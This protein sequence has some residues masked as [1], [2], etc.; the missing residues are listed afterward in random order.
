MEN[1]KQHSVITIIVII[2]IIIA[3]AIV[4][5]IISSS[6]SLNSQLTQVKSAISS[7]SVAEVVDEKYSE[8]TEL[9]KEDTKAKEV[10]ED[11]KEVVSEMEQKESTSLFE[12]IKEL[13]VPEKEKESIRTSFDIKESREFPG[14]YIF[15]YV[16]E[17]EKKSDSKELH[18]DIPVKP[19]DRDSLEK[20]GVVLGEIRDIWGYPP[21]ETIYHRLLKEK[22]SSRSESIKQVFNGVFSVKYAAAADQDPNF[23]G[24]YNCRANTSV[25]GYFKAYFADV[26]ANNNVGY[27]D[28][29]YGAAR[30]NEVCQ[31]LQDVA[32]LIKLDE[33]NVTPDIRFFPAGTSLPAGA[34][35]AASPYLGFSSTNLDNGA[36]HKYILS[37]Q[38][39]T[40]G[41]FDFDGLIMTN[42]N[43]GIIWDVDSPSSA[44]A[45]D[46]YTVMYHEVLHMLGFR[47]G[48]P[49]SGIIWGN[50][51]KYTTFNLFSFT[52]VSL[53]QQFVDSVTGFVQAQEGAPSPWFTT[54]DVVYQGKRN[55]VNASPDGIR[56]VYSPSVWE[57]ASSLS[58]FDMNRAPGETYIMNPTIGPNTERYIHQHE[59]EVLC[60]L[61]YTV[62]GL[63]EDPT[64]VAQDDVVM[65]ENLGDSVC[66]NPL[67]NDLSVGG[68]DLLIHTLQLVDVQ[69]GDVITYY[70][71]NDCTGAVLS[72]SDNA[73]SLLLE[74][75]SIPDMRIMQ[76]TVKDSVS[77]RYSFPAMITVVP[78]ECTTSDPD[79]HVCNGGFEM[80]PTQAISSGWG[81]Q[82]YCTNYNPA[83]TPIPWWCGY[84]GTPDIIE[85][86]SVLPADCSGFSGVSGCMV[87]SPDGSQRI[88]R[89]FQGESYRTILKQ[90]LEAGQ[91]YIFSADVRAT[92]SSSSLSPIH[93]FAELSDDGGANFVSTN[94]N[95]LYP[96]SVGGEVILDQVV[97]PQNSGND[98]TYVEHIFTPNITNQYLILDMGI[99]NSFVENFNI[100]TY[101]DNV[102][103]KKLTCV[104]AP[105]DLV[106]WWTGDADA[107][108]Y[109]NNH[110]GTLE[111]GA[112]VVT[113]GQVDAA[114]SFDGV[115]DYVL[116]PDDPNLTPSTNEFT[117]DFWIKPGS[118]LGEKTVIMK[119]K[120]YY[121]GSTGSNIVFQVV[122]GSMGLH[123][124]HSE[125]AALMPN[126]WNFVAVTYDGPNEEM[127]IYI[128]GEF[129]DVGPGFTSSN[130]PTELADTAFPLTFGRAIAHPNT[131]MNALLDEIEFF[132]RVLDESELFSIYNAGVDGKCK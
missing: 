87:D 64:P 101:I 44:S 81:Y 125:D 24:L 112:F 19:L 127:K 54:N 13:I 25:T 60:H 22:K 26:A 117:F 72:G 94:M 108:D 37:Q 76:Y 51:Q 103:I 80:A 92:S 55:V 97:A 71:D 109:Q 83:S 10:K 111:D 49:E 115:D 28:P 99:P 42:F 82:L 122:N 91:N 34:L 121:I 84:R 75:V 27:D 50:N 21:Q 16:F 48:L 43:P 85:S 74:P 41:P 52:D 47:N 3:L 90:P 126:E 30:R 6:S 53:V 58:H 116:V 7:K 8:T 66:I 9:K 78:V 59:K 12:R 95:F 124:A 65:A 118:N 20:E 105:D 88:G 129:N 100:T 96:Q 40:P 114:F 46:F 63:C 15:D 39:P 36:A 18:F 33:T 69:F 77:G 2:S 104:P 61:G 110:N 120:E 106:G 56:P 35:A 113:P 98:W 79:E 132:D 89:Y 93:F 5:G 11:T 130:F 31:V 4:Y 128:N 67:S 23:P 70:S 38:D 57:Q 107:S 123:T 131:A 102:S 32:E 45:Y 17:D 62:D 14:T 73:V 1:K 29:S 119:D 68:G 86:P